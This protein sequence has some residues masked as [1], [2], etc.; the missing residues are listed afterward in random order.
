[1]ALWGIGIQRPVEMGIVW[2]IQLFFLRVSRHWKPAWEIPDSEPQWLRHFRGNRERP[3]DRHGPWRGTEAIHWALPDYKD[4]WQPGLMLS[5][6]YKWEEIRNLMMGMKRQELM[7]IFWLW[8]TKTLQVLEDIPSWWSP[9]L[10][11]VPPAVMSFIL[12]GRG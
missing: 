7:T 4:P 6:G 5:M 3:V 11:L 8:A 2:N 12:W 9:C 10:Q 1:M